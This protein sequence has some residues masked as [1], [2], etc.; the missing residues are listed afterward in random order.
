MPVT[1]QPLLTMAGWAIL[2]LVLAHE[3]R[4]CWKHR[5]CPPNHCEC[6]RLHKFLAGLPAHG[7]TVT[8]ATYWR[9]AAKDLTQAKTVGPWLKRPGWHRRL[10]RTGPVLAVAG[11]LINWLLAAVVLAA[12]GPFIA[13]GVSRSA[14]MRMRRAVKHVA[15]RASGRV[16]TAWDKRVP[17]ALRSER[18][19]QLWRRLR[20]RDRVQTMGMLLSSITGTSSSSV[21]AGVT[22]NPDYSNAK[23]G[24]EVARWVLPRGFK[25]TAGEK[26]LAQEVWLS[27]IGFDLT[28]GWQLD[29]DEPVLVM[30]KAHRLPDLVYLH[31]LLKQVEELPE[32][33]TAIGL[34]DRG[35]LVCWNW[36]VENPHGL[37]NAGS[38]HGKTETEMAM[39]SQVLRKGGK[40]TYVDVKRVSIQGLKGLPNLTLLDNPRDMVGIWLAIDAWGKDLDDRIDDRTKDPTCEFDRDLLVLEEVNQLSE[41]FD[42]FWE[43][44]PEE[45]EE[46]KGTIL[47]KPKHAKKTPPIW[48]VIK[49]GV[50][51]GAFAKKNV[52]IA[53][54]NIEAQTVKGV[55][56]SI[57]MRLMG[58]YQPQNWKALVGT[59]PIPPAPPQKG[60]WCMINGSTQT[61][62]QALIADLDANESAVIWRDYADTRQHDPEAATETCPEPASDGCHSDEDAGPRVFTV[63]PTGAVTGA[64]DPRG[65]PVSLSEAVEGDWTPGATVKALRQDRYLSD[66]GELPDGLEFP[67]PVKEVGPGQTE[68]FWSNEIAEFNKVRRGSVAA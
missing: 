27:R 33:K 2:A 16:C 51:E 59:T 40:V 41:M 6:S 11:L 18:A 65:V 15:G 49:H 64:P 46:W 45:D 28:F 63:A 53:G 30:K 67:K 29:A 57:G 56:N 48:R 31:E 37:L 25:A 23:P 43:N 10:I 44:W 7:H 20:H 62:V 21:E 36:N 26:A 39:V 54:Q 1:V 14:R 58:G 34:D 55:R 35:K 17:P 13:A 47:W 19:V 60:R 38:R 22:W 32:H 66:R 12:L 3:L 4:W 8:D 24:D 52:L 9:H 42:E 68:R 61:W 50:W 5:E